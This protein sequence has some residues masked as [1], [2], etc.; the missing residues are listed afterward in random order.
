MEP[1]TRQDYI[2]RYVEAAT[3][4]LPPRERADHAAELRG[5]IQDQIDGRVGS[6]D[7]PAAA[8]L[9]VL[10]GMG[11]PAVLAAGYA[12]RP[13]HLIGPR[14][15]PTWRR[16][17]RIVLWWTLPFV[18][19]GVA[20]AMILEDRPLWGIVGPTIGV[21]IAAGAVIFTGMTI[22]YAALDRAGEPVGAWTVDHLP[23]RDPNEGMPAG[24]VEKIVLGVSV[25]FAI[26]GLVFVTASWAV[27]EAGPMSVL[28]PALWPWSLIVGVVLILA[29]AFVVIRARATG[30]WGMGSAIAT[31]LIALGWA[32]PIVWLAVTGLLFDPAFVEYLDIDRDARVVIVVC[33]LAATVAIAAWS[34]FDAF[35]RVLRR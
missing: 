6:G 19:F 32:V 35:R 14:W 2:G 27:P 18:A 26:A 1:I 23:S 9:A 12:D 17:L 34:T 25:L 21:T 4:S 33:I 3:R 20:L 11:D 7:T 30:R 28:N 13:L 8:E 5:S 22:V 31:A 29:G 10:S 24:R 15:Y 16:V